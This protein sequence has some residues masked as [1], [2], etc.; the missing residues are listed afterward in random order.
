MTVAEYVTT[1]ANRQVKDF[2]PQTGISNPAATAYALR[3]DYDEEEN[4]T[5]KLNRLLQDTQVAEI[6]ALVFGMWNS[7]VATDGDS[8]IL[9]NAL[10]EAK[11]QLSSLKALFIGDIVY[12]ES[13][14][15]WIEQSNISPV[16]EAYPQLE[17][18][19][20]RGGSGLQFTPVRHYQLK[21][22]IIQTGG[23]SSKTIS[24]I[25]ALHLPALEHLELWLGSDNYG[26]DSGVYTLRP[27]LDIQL[28]C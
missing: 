11:E 25:W 7:N 28:F 13:E 24:Q 16:L 3:V 10:V 20:V 8:R 22:L 19:Q 26:G 4:I 2:D 14:I 17:V 6:E 18:L 1:F 5:H 21:K 12:E 27:L 15:S 9:V 23:L